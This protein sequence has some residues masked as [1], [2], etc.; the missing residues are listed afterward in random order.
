MVPPGEIF[1][2]IPV[3]IGV[4]VAAGAAFGLAGFVLYW[5]VFRLVFLGKPAN[6][7]DRPFKRLSGVLDVVLGQ[8]RV[9]QSFS[10]KDRAGVGHVFIFWGFLAFVGSYILFIFLDSISKDLSKTI[11]TD[12]GVKVYT[13]ILDSF[14]MAILL[15]LTWAVLRRWLAKPNRLSFDITRSPDAVVIVSVIAGLMIFTFLIEGFYSAIVTK[16]SLVDVSPHIASPVGTVL[17]KLFDGLGVDTLNTLHGI[18]WWGHLGII[19]GFGIYI[20]FSKHMHMIAAPLNAFFKDLNARGTL[21]PIKDLETVETYGAGRVQ[22]LTW[23][24]L[25]DGYACAVCGRCTDNCPANLTG[26]ELSPMH[27]VENIKDHLLEVGPQVKKTKNKPREEQYVPEH[28][29]IG[30]AVTE[31]ALWQCVTC[32]ACEQECPV[33]CEHIDSIIDMR[34]NLVLEQGK[35][36]ES[37]MQA[38]RCMET[39][40]H[41]WRGTQATRLDWTQGLDI[42]QMSQ[43]GA[44]V[45]ILFWVGCT[46]ALEERGQKVAIAMAKILKAAGVNFAI[47]GE[48][49]TCTGDPA[50]RMGNEY[51]FQVMAQQNIETFNKYNVKKIVTICPHCFN[52]IKNEYPQLGGSYEIVHYVQYVKELIEQ[53]RL[54]LK[55]GLDKT[56]TYHDSCYLG[57]HNKIYDE[58]RELI[59]SIPGLKSV[60][61]ERRRERGFCCGAGGGHLW[62]E[63]TGSPTRINHMRTD[64]VLEVKPDIVGVSCPYCLQMFEEGIASKNVGDKI[65]AKD[66][67]ELIAEAIE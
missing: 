8:R 2:F 52:T 60:E 56:L 42:K 43:N 23:K 50:R 13:F 37:A 3:W 40:G 57:R 18:F 65:Q 31:E 45:E 63:E 61:M 9:L 10:R 64:H 34:R 12:G 19:L 7:F 49:E 1:G 54:K 21:A 17:G 15:A 41:P 38:L 5:R 4:Y 16:T 35:M 58:P 25:L 67:L 30:G 33:L 32:G 51:L 59:E 22:D 53:G 46:P 66:L 62:M 48:E 36:P 24:E 26:K 20:P 47:L 29:L 44:D 39:R 6:R 27:I 14:G 11:L 55:K 28:P